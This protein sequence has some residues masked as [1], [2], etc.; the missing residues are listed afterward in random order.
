MFDYKAFLATLPT[1]PGV[2]KMCAEN[3]RVLYIGKAKNLKRRV[4]SYFQKQHGDPKTTKLVGLIQSVDVIVTH[5][6]TEALI[7]ERNLIRSLKPKF[8]IIFRD[9][10]TYPYIY[11]ST[12]QPYPRFSYFRGSRNKKGR[13]F[14]PFPS[15]GAVRETLKTLQKVFRV[16]QCDDVFYANRSRPCLQHQI[17]RCSAPCV[18]AI[19]KAAYQKDVEHAVLFLEGKSD[20]VTGVL[21][22]QMELASAQQDFEGAARLRDK[23]VE[24]R[25]VQQKQYVDSKTGDYDIVASAV[26]QGD[27][28]VELLFIREGR[29]LGHKHFFPTT[30][31]P[32]DK[33]EVLEAFLEHYYLGDQVTFVPK[34]ILVN[35]SL[36]HSAALSACISNHIAKTVSIQQPK[37]G[38]RLQWLKLAETNANSALATRKIDVTRREQRLLALQQALKMA[39]IPENIECFDVS[40]TFGEQ[41]VASCVVFK[42][43]AANPSQ[44]RRFNIKG[45]TPGDDYAAIK[46]ALTRRYLSIKEKDESLLPDLLLIDGGKGQ[47]QQAISVFKELQ[48][49]GVVLLGVAKGPERKAG[50]ETLF[51]GESLVEATL[52]ED[53]LALH[54][55]QEVRDE[56]H[57]FAITGHR[58][59][60]AKVKTHSRLEDIEGIGSKKRQAVLKYFGG[61]QGVKAATV[62]ELSKVPGISLILAQRI[63]DRLQN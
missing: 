20:A 27:V 52:P 46:Q 19:D 39:E 53:S 45:I 48:I 36:N 18:K 30:E 9:D 23:I 49:E 42:G 14:G 62:E 58:L 16:R 54:L 21:T 60:R 61:L 15:A 10:K 35:Q 44:Y 33:V 13:F 28:C 12:E 38:D 26:A 4:S 11:V 3:G 43:G 6:E 22:E 41:T 57:R 25:Q 50:M 34:H 8:N 47:L 31:G 37:R 63:Y 1:Q 59:Q 51:L 32:V 5:T 7:L 24:L 40:H 55:I 17:K 56:A 2:Y 29:L